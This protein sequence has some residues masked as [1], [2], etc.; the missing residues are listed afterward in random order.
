MACIII[1][2]VERRRRRRRRGGEEEEEGIAEC[3]IYFQ[4][5]LSLPASLP[6]SNAKFFLTRG[7]WRSIQSGGGKGRGD[8]YYRVLTRK[9]LFSRKKYVGIIEYFPPTRDIRHSKFLT[10]FDIVCALVIHFQTPCSPQLAA[11]KK[12]N[13]LLVQK[14]TFTGPP[15][16]QTRLWN[17]STRNSIKEKLIPLL[18]NPLKLF[19]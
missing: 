16:P 13:A 10:F 3:V 8:R 17:R 2:I 12:K 7:G 5:S 6:H 9:K 1:I 14:K 19:F 4:P 11:G 15:F 18:E